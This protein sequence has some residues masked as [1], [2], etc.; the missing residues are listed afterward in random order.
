MKNTHEISLILVS[1]K[2]APWLGLRD[3]KC[4]N[5]AC[6]ILLIA[7]KCIFQ[8]KLMYLGKATLQ[9]GLGMKNV[10]RMGKTSSKQ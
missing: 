9:S 1:P 6:Y 3:R 8:C 5:F 7:G 2:C 10:F 4:Q